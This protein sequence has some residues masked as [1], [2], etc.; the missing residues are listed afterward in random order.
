VTGSAGGGGGM[1]GYRGKEATE[2]H[3]TLHDDEF[4][5][6]ALHQITFGRSNQGG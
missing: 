3:R 6:I 1:F 4:I 5:I 2:E